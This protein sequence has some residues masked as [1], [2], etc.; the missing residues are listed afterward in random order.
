MENNNNTNNNNK[1]LSCIICGGL[2]NQLFMILN[3]ISLSIDNTTNFKI[4]FDEN[5][6]KSYYNNNNVIRHLPTKYNLFKNIQLEPSHN[7]KSKDFINYKEKSFSYNKIELEENKKYNLC[8][9]FQSYKYFYHNKEKLKEYLFIDD[10]NI[11]EIKKKLNLFNK[12]TIGIHVRLGDY[13]K[14]EDYHSI[15]PNKYYEHL[16]SKFDKNEHTI[17][18]FSDDTINAHK[19][20][21]YLKINFIDA[22]TIYDDEEQQFL[23]FSLCDIKICSNST[24]SLMSTLINDIYNFK[25][26]T[27]SFFYYKLF[28]KDGPE[29]DIND[30]I[31]IKN[32]YAVINDDDIEYSINIKKI[33]ICLLVLTCN[34]EE[35]KGNLDMLQEKYL[36]NFKYDYFLIK[37]CNDIDKPYL[38]NNI[39]YVNCDECY[40]NLPK[41]MLIAYKYIYEHF[42]YDYFVKIDDSCHVNVNILDKF[43][44]NNFYNFH[45]L[46]KKAGG[47]HF[48]RKWHFGKCK[49]EVINKTE[50]ITEYIGTWCSG[51]NGYILSKYCISILIEKHNYN[52]IHNC[53]YEDKAISDVLRRNNVFPSY[54]YDNKLT[55]ST[56]K[57][58]KN[59]NE[60]IFNSKHG[61]C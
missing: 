30:I 6:P 53:I 27:K 20:L 8:G 61:F 15:I 24:Y 43:I 16:L 38:E 32:N 58:N 11:N 36:N 59:C 42:N 35:Y 48:N 50:D 23:M 5:Y 14:K 47:G 19:K 44:H 17:I 18:L 4:Y 26:N 9:Y 13:V 12:K 10:N 54:E 56:F 28:G 60:Y 49:N 57:F 37:A 34:K 33:K 3:L 41:K 25:I 55:I 46:G 22:D 51:G 52:Y 7:F 31:P 45:L 40:E 2:G 29:Y 21:D 39:L 1:S